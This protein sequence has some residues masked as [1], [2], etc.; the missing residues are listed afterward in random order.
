MS[1]LAEII[2]RAHFDGHESGPCDLTPSALERIAKVVAILLNEAHA[3]GERAAIAE[4]DALRERLAAVEALVEESD[5]HWSVVDGPDGE[6]VQEGSP[7]VSVDDLRAALAPQ[8]VPSAAAHAP[9]A[10]GQPGRDERG[11]DGRT[12]TV[13]VTLTPDVTEFMASLEQVE[14]QF[15]GRR[16]RPLIP[17]DMP[18]P[19]DQED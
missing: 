7:C 5:Y 16:P 3:E 17:R 13:T 18:H 9:E 8:D 19:D 14:R 12:D 6:Y 10:P 15:R 4:R 2:A 11:S 1:D